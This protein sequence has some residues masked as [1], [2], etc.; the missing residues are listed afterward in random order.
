[1]PADLASLQRTF[2]DAIIGAAPLA[3]AA[4]LVNGSDPLARLHVYA[5]A[6]FA[7]LHDVLVADYP[8][9]A[10]LLGDDAFRA[11]V[12]PY[13]RAHPTTN[14]SLREAGLHLAPFL[15]D[16]HHDRAHIDLA[17][18]ERARVEAFDR[19]DAT[20]LT[21]DMLAT[22]APEDFPAL[23]L[24]L[25]PTAQLVALATNADDRWDALEDARPAPPF[26]RSPR[27]V[28]VWRREV[29]VIHR[30]LEPD[31]VTPLLGIAGGASFADICAYFV[32][33]AH[34][35]ERALALLLRWLDA[36]ILVAASPSS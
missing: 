15:D 35:I 12:K 8:K 5:N 27:T 13:L 20:P 9:L 21:R 17:R 23:P 10:A 22:L 3:S 7:R 34:G 36:G 24:R 18:L 30:T 33:D 4:S 6:Y 19:A 2:H 28:L 29:T 26:A 1:V 14:P 32:G 25:V 11:L 31:E 16:T